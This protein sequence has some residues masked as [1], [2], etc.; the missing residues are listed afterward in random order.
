MDPETTYFYRFRASNVAGEDWG[1][2]SQSLATAAVVLPAITSLPPSV[3]GAN[4]ATVDGRLDSNGNQDPTVLIYWGLSDGD[5]NAGS[6]D[7]VVD[8]GIMEPGDFSATLTGLD[9]TTTYHYRFFASNSAGG[10]WSA[11]SQMFTTGEPTGLMISELMARNS[12][13]LLD[14]DGDSS[15]W[16]EIHNPTPFAIDLAGY[17]VTDNPGTLGQWQLPAVTLS[18]GEHLLVFAS[19]KDRSVAGSELHTNFGLGSGGEYL[20]L[21]EPDGATIAWEYAPQFPSQRADVSYGVLSSDPLELGYFQVPT[22]G[23]L[24]G[25]GLAGIVADTQYSFD[26]G[27]Y[28]TPFITTI[29]SDTP[30]ST[31]VYTT[32]GSEPSLTNGVQIFPADGDTPPRGDVPINTTTTLRAAAF[33]PGFL[34]TNVDTHTYIFLDDVIQQPNNPPGLPGTWTSPS[35]GADY[36]MDPSIVAA[37]LA[38]IKDD[39]QQLPT[40]SLVTDDDNLFASSTG[41]Y[42]NAS[43]RGE[44]W[45]RPVSMEL[46]YPDG[47]QELQVDAGLRMFGVASR[48]IE[49]KAF[50]VIFKSEYGPSKLNFPLFPDSDIETFNTLVIRSGDENYNWSFMDD[51]QTFVR[52]QWSKNV[53]SAMG[54][55]VPHGIYTHLYINGL[56]WGLYNIFER[57]DGSFMADHNGGEPEDYDAINGRVGT[58]QMIDGTIDAWNTTLALAG[59]GVI[60]DAAYQEFTQ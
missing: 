41:L 2:A 38:T 55:D 29:R 59:A 12:E 36:E 35:L 28:E 51:R 16:F 27:F 23:T 18:A 52:D 14:E 24:N 44:Q 33:K 34:P 40:L 60:D 6:W 19:S 43:Q 56:Y 20:A 5:T 17:F 1:T 32:D 46:I 31:L 21:V 7:D 54:K 48:G 15:D 22:P 26:R 50:R 30:G 47:S 25:P 13:A 58:V 9:G 11:A 57:P 8:L 4:T 10:V 53:E 42:M 45:E 49:K 39:L 3:V 37:N